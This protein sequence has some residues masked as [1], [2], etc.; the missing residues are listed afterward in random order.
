M[1]KRNHRSDNKKVKR[2]IR[3]N[4]SRNALKKN[5]QKVQKSRIPSKARNKKRKVIY[6][7]IK[8]RRRLKLKRISIEIAVALSVTCLFIWL[9][10]VFCFT[11]SKVEGYSMLPSLSE[12]ELVY[13]NKRAKITRFKLVYFHTPDQ[14]GKM[15]RRVIGLPGE[16]VEYKEDKL[17]I[18][19]SEKD[20]KFI[21]KEEIRKAQQTDSFFTENFSI[22]KLNNG[23][24]IIPKDSYLVL[25]DNRPYSTDSRYYGLVKK[26]EIIGV[27]EMR[28][29]PLHLM[30]K[31]N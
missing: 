31:F 1:S 6:R 2:P 14:P 18:N 8:K 26:T 12:N 20:E 17:Y 27:V 25:G 23:E 10:S 3:K 22:A 11:F 5:K 15:I 19:N 4:D 28:V 21:D 16:S 30:E 13:I 7:K 9:L 24:T 29:L